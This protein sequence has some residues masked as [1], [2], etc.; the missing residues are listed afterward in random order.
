M[1]MNKKSPVYVP[2]SGNEKK[3]CICKNTWTRADNEINK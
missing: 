3:P 1:Q 2:I